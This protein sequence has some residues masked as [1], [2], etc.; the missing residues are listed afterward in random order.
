MMSL[1]PALLLTGPSWGATN[2]E[3]LRHKDEYSGKMSEGVLF[4]IGNETEVP[5]YHSM[6]QASE[7]YSM[8]LPLLRTTNCKLS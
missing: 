1:I 7:V 6:E 5:Q 4:S 8:L 2:V 3:R